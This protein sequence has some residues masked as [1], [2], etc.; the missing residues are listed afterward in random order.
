MAKRNAGGDLSLS[1]GRQFQKL[2]GIV[3]SI[4]KE[5]DDGDGEASLPARRVPSL[6]I[7][8]MS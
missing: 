3:A 2:I 6:N 8:C 1:S 4:L 5:K 7:L